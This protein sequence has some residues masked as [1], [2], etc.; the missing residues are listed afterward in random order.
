MSILKIAKGIPVNHNVAIR[1]IDNNSGETVQQVSGHNSATNSMFIGIAKYLTGQGVLNQGSDLLSEYV[2]RYMS[3]GTMGLMNQDSDAN[4][5]PS[6]V[7][8]ISYK[9]KQYSDL[10]SSQLN[11]LNKPSSTSLITD[12][13]D[14]ILRYL[15]YLKQRPGYGSDGYDFNMMNNRDE[16]GLGPK[17]VDVPV[18]CELISSSFPR[19]QI[20]YRDVLPEYES[21]NKG[22]IDIIFSAM[23]STGAL[24]QFRTSEDG[25]IFI[26]EAGLWSTNIWA[27]SNPNGLLAGYRIAPDEADIKNLTVDKMPDV[28]SNIN[29][30]ILRV[31]KNQVVQIIWKLQLGA[32]DQFG[33]EAALSPESQSNVLTWTS[34]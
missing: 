14:K 4:G 16:A 29:K 3:V 26:T 27:S 10:T 33:G 24:K 13:D 12:E 18:N 19:S 34:W 25:H 15:D 1:V 31:D 22:T 5:Y 21:E 7:G 6:G 30:M 20:T 9:G 23:I 28:I 32:I 17:F 2:P 11:F 8:V